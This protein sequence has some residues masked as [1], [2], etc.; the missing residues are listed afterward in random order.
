MST[1]LATWRST[2]KIMILKGDNYEKIKEANPSISETDYQ[3][4]KLKCEDTSTSESS[5]W[6]KGMRELNLGVHRLG[7]GGYRVAEPK[8]EKENAEHAAQGLPPRFNKYKDKSTNNYLRARYKED[9][10]TKELTTDPK[11]LELERLLVKNTTPR[12][13]SSIWL[14]FKINEAKFLNGPRVPC[15][16]N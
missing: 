11:V 15:A 7:P 14:H 16:G 8:W 10:E 1:S 3:E 13:I 6:G 12:L 4:F 5:Q 2:V 9:P